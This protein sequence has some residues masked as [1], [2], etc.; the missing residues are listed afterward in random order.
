MCT[1]CPKGPP[2]YVTSKLYFSTNI[3]LISWE[4]VPFRYSSAMK[5]AYGFHFLARL[6][7]V[8]RE[9]GGLSSVKF[10]PALGTNMTIHTECPPVW[11]GAKDNRK[12]ENGGEKVHLGSLCG[13]WPLNSSQYCCNDD[14][15]QRVMVEVQFAIA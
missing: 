5:G 6:I 4:D 3:F 12:A 14:L 10:F 13:C 8:D 15:T 9:R 7:G 1:R 11:R 2:T